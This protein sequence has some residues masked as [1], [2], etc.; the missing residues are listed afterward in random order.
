MR[1]YIGSSSGSTTPTNPQARFPTPTI[2]TTAAFGHHHHH[3]WSHQQQHQYQH[4]QKPQQQ[5]IPYIPMAMIPGVGVGHMMQYV[6]NVPTD[7]MIDI[8]LP[9]PSFMHQQSPHF[10][11]Y[12]DVGPSSST[13]YAYT[14]Q[15]HAQLGGPPDHHDS[16]S[17][18]QDQPKKH[19][20]KS[21]AID[22][23]R[24]GKKRR[25]ATPDMNDVELPS[26][27]PKKVRLHHQPLTLK[28]AGPIAPLAS[29][30]SVNLPAPPP[31]HR[32]QTSRAPST[33][34]ID[35]KMIMQLK[36]DELKVLISQA[37][38]AKT[39][40]E[41][42]RLMVLAKTKHREL[43]AASIALSATS[44]PQHPQQQQGRNRS[45]SATIT[46]T[47]TAMS[48]ATQLLHSNPSPT[49]AAPPRYIPPATW[50]Y[51]QPAMRSPAIP[52]SG[53]TNGCTTRF[54]NLPSPELY[55]WDWSD[56][57][58]DGDVDEMEL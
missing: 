56:D 42:K 24:A 39:A 5:Y 50:R 40:A 27:P 38:V 20:Q 41:K 7:F 37:D 10:G 46:S 22:G 44:I 30:S 31:R 9:S 6:N 11:M 28:Q 1:D 48:A 43:E 13:A 34:P 47:T 32:R 3:S 16:V 8:G 29:M 36:M 26:S 21:I 33:P 53:G 4:Y 2:T 23:A 54:I 52:Q 58:L 25:G 57:E 45:S 55:A 49:I 15:S 35:L 12:S 19:Y 51:S 18:L 17:V 14:N